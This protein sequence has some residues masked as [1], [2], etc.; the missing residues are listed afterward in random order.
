MAIFFLPIVVNKFSALASRGHA[1]WYRICSSYEWQIC[2]LDRSLGDSFKSRPACVDP[3][4][5]TCFISPNAPS[6]GH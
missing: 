4:T 3:E 1:Q 2:P 6:R 5:L